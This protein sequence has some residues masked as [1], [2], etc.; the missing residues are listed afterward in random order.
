VVRDLAGQFG[1]GLPLDR[2]FAPEDEGRPPVAIINQ[3]MARY[4]FGASN[5]LGRQFTVEGQARPLEIIGVVGDAKYND[6][7]DTPP[8]TS[9]SHAFQGSGPNLKFVLRT[10]VPPMSLVATVRRT[11][12][13]VLPD[14]P[15]AKVT[16]LAEQVDATI[17]PER[18]VAMLSELF[19]VLAALLLTIGLYGLLAYTVTRRLHEIGIRMAIGATSRD[20]TRMVLTSALR[21]V[22]AGLIIGIPIA[23]WTKGYAARVLAVMA[24]SQAEA[25]VTLPVEITMPIVVAAIAML[26]VALV[27]SYGPGRRATR[28]DPVAALRSE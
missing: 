5:P 11:I 16:T 21:L 24:A 20:V 23:R 7:H 9:Y 8:R 25:P 10:D 19:G 4:Y 14:V 12:R 26:A 13:D 15:V 17:L 27:A 2:D 6:V 3:A 18:L 28:I 1:C 22:V